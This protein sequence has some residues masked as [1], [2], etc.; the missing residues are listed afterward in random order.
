MSIGV[1]DEEIEAYNNVTKFSILLPIFVFGVFLLDIVV[2]CFFH[3]VFHPWISVVKD[4]KEDQEEDQ[5]EL[6]K[7]WQ[8]VIDL[9]E[10][11]SQALDSEQ[12]HP[13]TT[14][15]NEGDPQAQE[16]EQQHL[17]AA[18]LEK[19]DTQALDKEQQHPQ[20]QCFDRVDPQAQDNELQHQK[21]TVLDEGET[22]APDK[23]QHLPQSPDH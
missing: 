21:A 12:Q 10:G 11:E 16:S 5:K 14:C 23:E 17:Q 18:D 3:F 8:Q 1:F 7:L 22:Q 19:G 6:D 15:N 20:D 9:E 13:K 4:K 2:I